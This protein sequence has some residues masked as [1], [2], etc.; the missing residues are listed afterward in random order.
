M[1]NTFVL[2]FSDL[3]IDGQTNC[4]GT[5]DSS[6]RGSFSPSLYDQKFIAAGDNSFSGKEKHG[7]GTNGKAEFLQNWVNRNVIET[8]ERNTRGD[9]FALTK[10]SSEG[11]KKKWL[12]KQKPWNVILFEIGYWKTF[13]LQ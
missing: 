8:G 5:D 6:S 12:S 10:C 3:H 7:A 13:P 1:C 2:G 4:C 11:E 9:K